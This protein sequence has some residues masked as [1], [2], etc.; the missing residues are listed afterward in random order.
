LT[1]DLYYSKIDAVKDNF[2]RVLEY[3]VLED[4]IYNRYFIG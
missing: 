2:E 4:W 1:A 3:D